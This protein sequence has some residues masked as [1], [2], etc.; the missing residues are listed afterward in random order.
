MFLTLLGTSCK[1]KVFSDVWLLPPPNANLSLS[2]VV[3]S[4]TCPSKPSQGLESGSVVVSFL[5]EAI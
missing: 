4:F 5:Q 3:K 2:K 1:L